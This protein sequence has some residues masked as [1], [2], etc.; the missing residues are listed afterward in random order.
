MADADQMASVGVRRTTTCRIA[1]TAGMRPPAVATGGASLTRLL[2]VCAI[3]NLAMLALIAKFSRVRA[4][5]GGMAKA[6]AHQRYQL[7]RCRAAPTLHAKAHTSALRTRSEAD[8]SGTESRPTPRDSSSGARTSTSGPSRAHSG[9]RQS[10]RRMV[11][12]AVPSSRRM[13]AQP[14]GTTPSGEALM[15]QPCTRLLLCM[16]GRR[17]QANKALYLQR[18]HPVH[19]PTP[20]RTPRNP[21]AAAVVTMTIPVM[22][23]STTATGLPLSPRPTAW[24]GRPAGR[25][26]TSRCST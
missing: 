5:Q 15:A 1:T 19:S 24:S 22:T 18:L 12:P 3:V 11:P 26:T 7:R 13:T 8:T 25:T 23:S 14:N 20:T 21:Q 2:P 16:M 6:V 10:S 4:R 9:A 17:M